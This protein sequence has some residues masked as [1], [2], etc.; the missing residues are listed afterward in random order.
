ML[1]FN[2]RGTLYER[3]FAHGKVF[4]PLIVEHIEATCKLEPGHDQEIAD[5]LARLTKNINAVAPTQLEELRGI[6][7]GA[8]VEPDVIMKLCYWPDVTSVTVGLRFCS[9]VAFS[10]LVGG[11]I[12][13][14]NSDH[15]LNT[16][17][18][19]MLQRVDNS[20]AHSYVR[21]TFLGTLGT[22]AGLN[23]AGLAMTTATIV[24]DATNWDGVPLMV[25]AQAILEQ[26]STVEE[27]IAL[28][29]TMPTLN[30]SAHLT[31]GDAAGNVADIERL[32]D[33]MGVRRPEGGLLFNTNHPLATNTRD[34]SAAEP[35]LHEN[36]H[37]RYN[38]LVARLPTTPH[39]VEGLQALL[40]DHTQP[41]AI[42]QHGGPA[43][44]H[45]TSSY[46]LLP[47][48]GTMLMAPGCPCQH[49]FIPLKV[50]SE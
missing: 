13:A 2:S 30:Y 46:V 20:S 45:T 3:G 10:D 47:A 33:R 25:V 31:V 38:R 43:D 9:L 18:F 35:A 42:C 14:K 21:G 36:S 5:V 24:P 7:D 8:G 1:E 49:E 26:C 29:E 22:R 37:L 11:P 40:R 28:A 50:H 32:P 27:A 12:L 6:A 34:H 15:P 39:T 48:Q 23:D 4:A 44:L 16:V 17:R 41:G 19:L